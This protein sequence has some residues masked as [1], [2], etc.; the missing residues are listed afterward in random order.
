MI[1]YTGHQFN[2]LLLTNKTEYQDFL[3]E[4]LFPVSTIPEK[5]EPCYRASL[6]GWSSST[7]HSRCN[8]RNIAATITLVKVGNYFFGGYTDYEWRK[9]LF[10][11]FLRLSKSLLP[12]AIAIA[13]AVAVAV[14]VAVDVDVAVAVG[15]GVGVGVGVD[16]DIVILKSS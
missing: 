3:R 10:F 5:W 2:S 9:I 16:I 1:L 8:G 15:V 4:W 11:L 6:H 14:A 13:I 7:F 12:I